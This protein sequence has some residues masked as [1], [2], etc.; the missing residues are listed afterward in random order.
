MSNIVKNFFKTKPKTD[1]GKTP[2]QQ[3]WDDIQRD[4]YCCD[5]MGNYK[6]SDEKGFLDKEVFINGNKYCLVPCDLSSCS[7]RLNVTNE[8]DDTVFSVVILYGQNVCDSNQHILYIQE[9]YRLTECRC[10]IGKEMAKYIREMAESR[11]FSIIGVHAVAEPYAHIDAMNQ[12][13]LEN[14]YKEYLNGENV[15]LELME[16]SD[17]V[18]CF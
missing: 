14:F 2:S 8:A 7:F 16:N 13:Q 4:Y 17:C 1:E 5:E 11:G 3:L 6:L 15:R 10:G 18:K 12:E 9:F